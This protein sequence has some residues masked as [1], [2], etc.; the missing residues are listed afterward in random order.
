MSNQ[1]KGRKP[2]F[3]MAATLT[4]CLAVLSAC[5]HVWTRPEDTPASTATEPP[6]VRLATSAPTWTPLPSTPL[7]TWTPAPTPTPIIYVIQAG[8]NLIGIASRFGVSAQFLQQVNGILDPRRLQIGQELL[9]PV[10]EPEGGPILPTQTPVPVA[11]ENTGVFDTSSGTAWLLG[12]AVNRNAE[13]VERVAVEGTLMDASGEVV[14][15]AQA[16]TALQ[17]IAPGESSAFAISFA[18]VPQHHSGYRVTLLSADPMQ[19][20]GHF[21][22]QCEAE[23]RDSREVAAG[24]IEVQGTVKNAGEGIARCS[25]VLTAFDDAG[26]VVAVREVSSDPAILGPGE[27]GVFQDVIV[28]LGGS[29]ARYT[30]QSQ[31]ILLGE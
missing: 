26:R 13:P 11:I 17:I 30:V 5:G 6:T 14:A 10:E 25:A 9:I 28:S 7:P 4:A 23:A 22:L 18:S 31:G 12:V 27:E 20:E 19:Y 3:V 16:F 29:I 15:V 1:T 2:I 21:Y 8:D 24:S